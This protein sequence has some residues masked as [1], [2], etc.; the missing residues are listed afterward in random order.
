MGDGSDKK[1]SEAELARVRQRL[2]QVKLSSWSQLVIKSARLLDEYLLE[3]IRRGQPELQGLRRTHLMLFPY[4]SL[5]GERITTLAEHIGVSKQAVGQLVDELEAM[6]MVERVKDPLDGR[7]KL[8]RF[9]RGGQ[10]VIEGVEGMR[11]AELVIEAGLQQG[12]GDVLRRILP[13]LIDELER[14]IEDT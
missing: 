6:G 5:G 12:D 9:A 3:G 11:A 4:I 1:G 14:L 13:G 2:E 10:V 7:A 8:V